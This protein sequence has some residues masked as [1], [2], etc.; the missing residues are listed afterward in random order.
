MW[1]LYHLPFGERGAGWEYMLKGPGWC[2]GQLHDWESLPVQ[3]YVAQG[4]EAEMPKLAVAE[5]VFASLEAKAAKQGKSV[6]HLA[7][8][9]LRAALM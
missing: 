1:S 9:A 8:E 7:S 6:A 5:D 4:A 2:R 3:D